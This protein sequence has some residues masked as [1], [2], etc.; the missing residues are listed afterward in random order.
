MKYEWKNQDEYKA[1]QKN[2]CVHH[3]LQPATLENRDLCKSKLSFWICI[4]SLTESSSYAI[5]KLH[6]GFA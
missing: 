2:R 3:L 5:I 4:T 6:F 1:R